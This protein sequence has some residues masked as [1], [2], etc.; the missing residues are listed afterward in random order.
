MPGMDGFEV[1]EGLKA[2]IAD[3]YLPVIVPHRPAGHKL[4]RW[5]SGAKDFISKPFD[6]AEVK[7]RIYNMLE[8]RAVVQKTR[9]LQQAVGTDGAGTNRRTARKRS[10]LPQ[11]DRTG[12]R[13]VLGT[14]RERKL[15]QGLRPVLEMRRNPASV[16]WRA[17]QA[18][19]RWQAGMKRSGK[20]YRPRLLPG[21]RSWISHTAVVN[22]DGSQQTFRVSGEPIST[23][24]A[25]SSVTAGIGV[26]TGHK[27]K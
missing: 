2:N 21:S 11:L 20:Y 5:P 8:V 24:P 23:G 9:E 1:M 27:S 18:V 14:G 26:E 12:L 7:T 17:S 6:L 13:L 19:S 3:G 15:H 4:R 22:A 25:V 10:A 16:P